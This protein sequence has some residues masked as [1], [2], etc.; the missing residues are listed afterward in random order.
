MKNTIKIIDL[1]SVRE[2]R[3]LGALFKPRQLEIIDKILRMEK[4]SKIENEVY[5]RKIKKKLNAIIDVYNIAI[6]TRSKQ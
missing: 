2:R 4:L 1:K 6:V 5:S 3:A